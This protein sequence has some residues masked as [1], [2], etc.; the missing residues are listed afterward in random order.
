MLQLQLS[1]LGFSGAWIL[2]SCNIRQDDL[3]VCQCLHYSIFNYQHTALMFLLC[4]AVVDVAPVV[5]HLG[6]GDQ[7]RER[8]HPRH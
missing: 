1:V 8:S 4:Q 3:Q 7:W 2:Q 5:R 6:G